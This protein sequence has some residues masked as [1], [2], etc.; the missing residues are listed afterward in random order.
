VTALGFGNYNAMFVTYR[1]REFHGV[2]L[3]SNF[4]WSRA[5]G[6][7]NVAQ[8][9][10]D[11]TSLNPFNLHA[12]YGP[13]SYDI[14]LIFNIAAYYRPDVY[15]SQ[16]GILGHVIGGWTISPLFTAQSGAP[17]GVTMAE[18]S[19]T[20][21]Q[22][23]GEVA[24]S[25]SSFGP[26]N[27]NAVLNSRFTGGNSANYNVAGSG[28]VGTN[29]STG[30][31]I[32]SN[33]ATVYSEF[34]R[35]I[36]GYDTSCGGYGNLRNLPQYNLDAQALKDIGMWKEGRVG[37]TLSFQITNVLNH[38]QPGSPSLS[39]TGPTTFGRITGQANTPR[40][41]EFGLRVHF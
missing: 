22:A 8:S 34:R 4:T 31:N 3:T 28:G 25:S 41:M 1:M 30:V 32:F 24:A 21:C 40:N 10:S 16:K 37:A 18:G 9:S 19:C 5:L 38:M 27:E 20:G 33:P 17:I 23:F 14:P 7:A 12:G 29:N 2:S 36:L 6:T 26:Y 39:I 15:R 13:Q 35:C 11:F